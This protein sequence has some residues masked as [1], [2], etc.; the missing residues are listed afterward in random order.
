MQ[1]LRTVRTCVS[2]HVLGPVLRGHVSAVARYLGRMLVSDDTEWY[3][4]ALTQR[5]SPIGHSTATH[6]RIDRL[7]DQIE[8]CAVTPDYPT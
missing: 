2:F 1:A 8:L 7:T 4:K 5:H 3:F 6:I